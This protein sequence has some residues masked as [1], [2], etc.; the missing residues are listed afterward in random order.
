MKRLLALNA[1]T[2]LMATAGC[3]GD[4]D[5]SSGS[6]KSTSSTSSKS[7]GGGGVETVTGTSSTDTGSDVEDQGY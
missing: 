4:D 2:A 5:S 3:G 6:K 7:S 1:A